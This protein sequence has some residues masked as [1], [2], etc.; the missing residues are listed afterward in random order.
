MHDTILCGNLYHVKELMHDTIL[1]GN[2][3]HVKE[4]MHDTI[5]MWYPVSRQGTHARHNSVW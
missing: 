1:C 3:Y 4:L 2:L 5:S